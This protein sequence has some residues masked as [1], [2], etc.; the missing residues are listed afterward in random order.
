[1]GNPARELH[2]IFAH[3]RE[4]VPEKNASGIAAHVKIRQ[5]AGA[6]E[7]LR[8]YALLADM[9]SILR[10]LALQGA[11]V[12]VLRR[13]LHEWSRVPLALDATW[14]TSTG[15][16]ENFMPQTTLDQIET[17]ALYLDGKV[18]E[19]DEPMTSA[20]RSLV[21]EAG[22]LLLEDETLPPQLREYLHY[23]LQ[24]IRIALDD[25]EIG[26]AFDFAEAT[27]RLWVAMQAAAGTSKDEDQ[28]K[29]W[30]KLADA[31]IVGT[32]SSGLVEAGRATIQLMIGS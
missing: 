10:R 20:L 17:F 19:F 22:K 25:E 30:G 3:W 26:R 24:E 2:K 14:N 4:L 11:P 29:S 31:I 28:R 15:N 9:D 16:R 23:L 18:L 13:Q 21:D 8:V 5:E 32:V 6:E 12:A 27:R 7:M 1:M